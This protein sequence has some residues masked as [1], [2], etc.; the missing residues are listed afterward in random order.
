MK[1]RAIVVCAALGLLIVAAQQGYSQS[2]IEPITQEDIAEIKALGSALDAAALAG[3]WDAIA[4]LFTEDVCL[5]FPN[6]P[7][8]RGREEFREWL[9]SVEYSASEHRIEFQEVDGYGDLAYARG[10]GT[11]TFIVTGM[12]T[13]VTDTAKILSIVRKQAEGSWRIA[14]WMWSSDLPVST[15]GSE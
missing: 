13:P 11:E 6:G 12:E 14:I 1:H 8:L 3:D 5:M 4:A 9:G 7:T 10:K 2:V 15:E